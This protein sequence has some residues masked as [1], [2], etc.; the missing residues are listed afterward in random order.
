MSANIYMYTL[1][2]GHVYVVALHVV[3]FDSYTYNSDILSLSLKALNFLVLYE[4]RLRCVVEFL[5][6]AAVTRKL[7]F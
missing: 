2:L 7:A 4:S 6:P 5:Q 1:L 3:A